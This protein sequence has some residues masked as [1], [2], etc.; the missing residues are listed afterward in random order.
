MVSVSEAASSSVSVAAS[1]GAS[2]SCTISIAS[3]PSGSS[4]AGTDDRRRW[5]A[6]WRSSRLVGSFSARSGWETCSPTSQR[7]WSSSTVTKLPRT[8][9]ANVAVPARL[10]AV[11]TP[12]RVHRPSSR[13][14]ASHS[15]ADGSE[16]TPRS[17]A[18]A[19]SP[20][21]RAPVSPERR[22]TDDSW[23]RWA[24]C[25]RSAS[26]GAANG[27]IRSTVV[28]AAWA[29]DS[30]DSPARMRAWMSR[31]RRAE[32]MVISNWPMRACSPRRAARRALSASRVYSSPLSPTRSSRL[33]SSLSPASVR[34]AI[35]AGLLEAVVVLRSV[36][37][38][39]SVDAPHR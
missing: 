6:C 28:C 24:T 33:P 5:R 38:Y 4:S 17:W 39:A 23:A 9:K 35:G 11:K 12:T 27:M 21:V 25:A 32:S 34:W 2:P 20:R 15:T 7:A 22:R 10:G 36:R 14:Q 31:G 16:P 29:T 37:A 8:S 3:S 1:A 18:A 19:A 13:R 26:T 30:A